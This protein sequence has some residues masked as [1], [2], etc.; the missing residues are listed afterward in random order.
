MTIS[1]FEN[2]PDT[3][4][5]NTFTAFLVVQTT[6]LVT[7]QGAAL[8]GYDV[9]HAFILLAVFLALFYKVRSAQRKRRI[10]LPGRVRGGD[11]RPSASRGSF[12]HGNLGTDAPRGAPMCA[13]AA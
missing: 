7:L 13:A 9:R 10:S 12:E 1:P 2:H 3:A 11:I 4:Q 5:P 8:L 6:F